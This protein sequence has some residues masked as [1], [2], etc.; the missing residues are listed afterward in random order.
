MKK[1]MIVCVLAISVG[2]CAVAQD[3]GEDRLQALEKKAAKIGHMRRK[4][5]KLERRIQLLERAIC[6]SPQLENAEA[7]HI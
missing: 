6:K 3:S 1:L 4:I 7:S 5:K 2:I